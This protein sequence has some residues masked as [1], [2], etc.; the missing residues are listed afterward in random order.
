ME[1]SGR[2]VIFPCNGGLYVSLEMG[3]AIKILLCPV[4]QL[5]VFVP[6]RCQANHYALLLAEAVRKKGPGDREGGAHP[7]LLRTNTFKVV[8][9]VRGL[10][11]LVV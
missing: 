9:D 1:L 4:E 2:I 5:G 3:S 8:V 7:I 11:V 10:D 6:Q